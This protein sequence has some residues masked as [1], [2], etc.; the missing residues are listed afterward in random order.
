MEARKTEYKGIEFRSKSEAMFALWLDLKHTDMTTEWEYEPQWA[1]VGNYVPDFVIRRMRED[2][3][4]GNIGLFMNEIC[5]FEYKPARPTGTYLRDICG[6]LH[7]ACVNTAKLSTKTRLTVG[8][9]IIF[10]SIY[11]ADRGMYYVQRD[12]SYSVDNQDFDWIGD[13]HHELTKYRFDLADA[14]FARESQ[15]PATQNEFDRKKATAIAELRKW[16]ANRNGR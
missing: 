8:A 1:A 13:H 16:E 5:F 4:A 6:K 7:T 2:Y 3:F 14:A 11:T 15:L 10:G 9:A 12:G